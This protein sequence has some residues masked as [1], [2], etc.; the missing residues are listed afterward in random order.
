MVP[1]TLGVGRWGPEVPD[2]KEVEVTTVTSWYRN[3]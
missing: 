3:V 2:L 1:G